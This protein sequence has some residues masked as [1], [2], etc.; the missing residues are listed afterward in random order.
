LYSKIDWCSSP[1]ISFKIT[2]NE[3]KI[4]KVGGFKNGNWIMPLAL[5]I[6]VL[7]FIV[8]TISGIGY[9]IFFAVPPFLLLMY[10]ITLG[11]KKYLTLKEI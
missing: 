1:E 2:D 6:I 8:K 10:Y 9:L 5:G 3:T 7:S 11:R 4:F